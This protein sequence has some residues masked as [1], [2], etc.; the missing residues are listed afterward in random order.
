MSEN[1]RILIIDDECPVADLLS[2]FCQAKGFET[3]VL[4]RGE[5]VLESVKS[6]QP[7]LIT[8][9]IVM[10]GISGIEILAR[11]KGDQETRPIPVLIISVKDESAEE[12]KKIL[13]LCQGILRKPIKMQTLHDKIE[14]IMQT[15]RTNNLT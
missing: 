1:A 12:V 11:L 15:T 8:L 13:S 10:P 2:E 14:A 4:N 3:T 6:W 5:N 7:D 9:D